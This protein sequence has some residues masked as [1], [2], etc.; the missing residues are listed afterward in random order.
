[1]DEAH[2]AMKMGQAS[3]PLIAPWF[4]PILRPILSLFPGLIPQ[5]GPQISCRTGSQTG[6]QISSESGSGFRLQGPSLAHKCRRAASSPKRISVYFSAQETPLVTR[7]AS[8]RVWPLLS[9]ALRIW[10]VC[11]RLLRAVMSSMAVKTLWPVSLYV[12]EAVSCCGAFWARL[13]RSTEMR[14]GTGDNV[15]WN[16]R[17]SAT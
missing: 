1:M 16:W 13:W 14:A 17:L 6:S 7:V 4:R 12:G 10:K 2:L 5:T 8:S 11:W 15:G 3:F 9:H